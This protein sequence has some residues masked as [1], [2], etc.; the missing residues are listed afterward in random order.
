MDYV[1]N[2]KAKFSLFLVLVFSCCFSTAIYASSNVTVSEV[3]QAQQQWANGVVAVGKAY[4]D[5]KNYKA[6]AVDLLN[7]LYAFDHQQGMVLFKPTKAAAIPFR[8]TMESALSY[9]VG[10]NGKFAEDKG[11]ALQPWTN[12]KF[13]ND[14][15]YLHGNIAIAMGE[16][17][18][19]AKSGGVTKVEY[20]FGYVKNDK[21]QLKIFLHHSSL[22]FGS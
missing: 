3:N 18:F 1:K 4:T 10:D 6:V 9:F 2:V 14:E 22:P 8:G 15:I 17:Y 16:Y 20:T 19:T 21:G 13:H 12:V 5:K 11:F 7:K